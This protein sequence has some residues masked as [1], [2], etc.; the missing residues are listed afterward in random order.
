[1]AGKVND[2]IETMLQRRSVRKYTP[3]QISDGELFAVLDCA[4]YAPTS[5]NSQASRFIVIQ[6]A[7][8]LA[9]L[10]AEICRLLSSMEEREG[11][12][13]NVG[14]RAARRE[15]F[16]FFYGARTLITAVAPAEN[17]NS[18]A[19]CAAGLENIQLAAWSLGLGTCWSNQ[20]RWLRNHESIRKIF[21]DLG[22]REDEDIFGSVEIGYPEHISARERPRKAG[23]VLLDTEK[24][25]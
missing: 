21:L 18:M 3:Q 17:E 6:D 25:V 1:M 7:E 16:D 19:N 24:K 12:S 22:M 8:R 23:R 13:M 4:L 9:Y 11:Q 10:N 20:A 2:C 15:G 14:I 5:G